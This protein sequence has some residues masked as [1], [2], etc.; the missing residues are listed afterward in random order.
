MTTPTP[1]ALRGQAAERTHHSVLASLR[2]LIPHRR[3]S[4]GEALRLTELQANRFRQL[5]GITEPELDE[6]VISSLPRLEVTY[7]ADLPVSG[8]AQWHNGRWI[9]ALNATEAEVRQRFSLA[10]ELF[11]VINHTTKSWLHPA[12]ARMNAYD[13]GE[14]LADYFAGCLLMPKRHVKALHGR[15]LDPKALADTFGVSRRA[16]QV[17]LD[18]LGVTEPMPRCVQTTNSYRRVVKPANYYSRSLPR[19]YRHV[20]QMEGVV[21]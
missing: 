9:V 20:P 1:T 18:Q 4:P 2:Q 5:F 16:M 7:E 14:K 17:R 12:D 21:V 19:A 10:H 6:A 8:L 11:H 3:L 15:G 13:K